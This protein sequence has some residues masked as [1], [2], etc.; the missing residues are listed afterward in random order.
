MGEASRGSSPVIGRRAGGGCHLRRAWPPDAPPPRLAFGL[1]LRRG[2]ASRGSSP[3]IGRRAWGAEPGGTCGGVVSRGGAVRCGRA[4]RCRGAKRERRLPWGPDPRPRPGPRSRKVEPWVSRFSWPGVGNYSVLAADVPSQTLYVGAR[5]AIF[6]LPRR[7]GDPRKIDWKVPEKHR[8]AC[9]KKGKK[10]AE[11]HN[12]VQILEFVNRT[13]IFACGTFAFDPQCGFIDTRSFHQVEHL[14]S[15]RGRCPFDP[16][17]SSAAVM[18]GGVLYAATVNNFLGSEPIISRATGSPDQRVRTENSAAWLNAP[19]FVAAEFVGG[20]PGEDDEIYFFFTETAREYGSNEKATVPRLARV[21]KGDLGG[22]KT[23]QRRWTTFLKASLLCPDPDLGRSFPVLRDVVTLTS[24]AE[25][26]NGDPQ[27]F[28]GLFSSQRDG[29]ETSAI[30][31]FSMKS[32]QE[33]LSG[34]FRE[35]ERAC[36]RWIPVTDGSV[37]QPRPGRCITSSMKVSGYSSSLSMPDRVLAFARDHPLMDQAVRPDESCPLLISEGASYRQLTGHRVASLSGKE[38]DVLYLGTEHGHL[39]RAVRIGP[40]ILVLEARELF[41]EPQPVRSLLLQGDWLAVGSGGEVTGVNATEC[42]RQR[43]CQDCVLAR[44]PACAWSLGQGACVAHRH[45]DPKGL[46][47]DIESADI[48]ALCP[49]EKAEMPAEAEVPVVPAAHVVLPCSPR[50]SWSSCVWH[51]PP[52]T[53]GPVSQRPDGLEFSVTRVALGQYTCE[54]SEAGTARVVAAYRLVWGDEGS[55]ERG[56]RSR[57][58]GYAV[59][60]GLAGFVL[61]FAAG[62]LALLGHGR[63]R[64]RRRQRELLARDKAGLDLIPPSGTTSCSHEPHTPS[65]PEDEH[66]PLA[67]G[68]KNGPN[69]FPPSYQRGF[70]DTDQARIFLAEAPLAKCDETSI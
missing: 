34:H 20:S 31:T 12:Y 22:L 14:E 64:R 51:L 6:A 60:V 46:V 16:T 29:S 56:R 63:R 30:C 67:G 59:A 32:I 5:D 43:T 48:S 42:G 2:V 45:Q 24:P 65:S 39:H 19:S 28:Y 55:P 47:Q 10:E 50:S 27:L 69:G 17:Q 15:G 53:R 4:D 40:Q 18:V 1:L 62:G 49:K 54:C 21:C 52:G 3:V 11:C 9:R 7:H 26:G 25:G 57:E 33:A 37:P 38:Y 58:R 35:F 13:H 70:P 68:A 41:E 66:H 44:D 61:G 36:D 23:L 8:E